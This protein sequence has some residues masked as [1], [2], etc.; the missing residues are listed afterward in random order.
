VIK[1]FRQIKNAFVSVQAADEEKHG[2][3]FR[4]GG[5][6]PNSPPGDWSGTKA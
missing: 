6:L 2:R 3:I 1:G 4:N 5:F